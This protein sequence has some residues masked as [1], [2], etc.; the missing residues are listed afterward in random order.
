[1]VARGLKKWRENKNTFKISDSIG[2]E[3][4]KAM[5]KL[6]SNSRQQERIRW[7]AKK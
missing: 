5:I 6:K 3:I 4:E 2:E 1:M 7:V